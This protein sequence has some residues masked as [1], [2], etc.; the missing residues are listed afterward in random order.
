LTLA[1]MLH[2]RGHGQG[3][4][5]EAPSPIKQFRDALYAPVAR[6]RHENRMWR[7]GSAL[8]LAIEFDQ[9][10]TPDQAANWRDMW[11]AT[12]EGTSGDTTA[13]IGG[14]GTI[15]PI[16]MTAADAQ[17]VE[18]AKLTVTDASR[19]MGVPANLLGAQLEKGVPNL[20][21]DLA[22]WLRF[23][24][25]PELFR[26]EA[27]LE[28]DDDLFGD[29]PPNAASVYPMFDTEDFIRGDI[30]T[31]DQIAH[32]RVQD[33]RMLVDEWRKS[34]GLPPYPDG[35]GSIPQVVPVGGGPNPQPPPQPP[36]SQNGKEAS[37]QTT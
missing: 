13:V 4:M 29:A 7:R 30:A 35:M 31:E 27:A 19:I 9:T 1:Q 24:L 36:P 33:G 3:G 12:Y 14:G 18:M 2:I 16:G 28:A 32:Q 37:P 10:V 11:Q 34:Q 8:Q 26:I 17:F 25:G 22:T 15:K 6:Q 20:E 23:G 21:Q 5:W